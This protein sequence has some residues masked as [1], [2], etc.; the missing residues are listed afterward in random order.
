MKDGMITGRDLNWIMMQATRQGEALDFAQVGAERSIPTHGAH[1]YG[2]NREPV[3]PREEGG[4]L[5][6]LGH[7]NAPVVAGFKASCIYTLASRAWMHANCDEDPK[8]RKAW[9]K[10]LEL[11]RE[12]KYPTDLVPK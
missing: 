1:F 9:R 4:A 10:V 12:G 2:T 11:C 5:P 3:P 8:S 7:G 6:G